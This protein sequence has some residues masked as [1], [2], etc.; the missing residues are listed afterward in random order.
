MKDTNPYEFLRNREIIAIL[1]GDTEYGE[2]KFEDDCA[3]ARISMPY[4]SGP[5]LCSLCTMFGLPM[6][7]TWG[8]VNLS[9]WQYLDNLLAHCIKRNRCSDLL[10][11]LFEKQQFSSLLSGHTA[12][13]VD[14]AYEHFTSTILGKR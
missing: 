13:A 1:D 9:R 6:T 11:H 8:G 4:L 3:I 14:K 10:S 5:D 2:Y 7:Y 12:D